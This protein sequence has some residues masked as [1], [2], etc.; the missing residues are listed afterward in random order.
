MNRSLK[1]NWKKQNPMVAVTLALLGLLVLPS[2]AE[3][4]R[5]LYIS[6]LAASGTISAFDFT[7]TGGL[8]SV[9]DLR[10]LPTPLLVASRL[11]LMGPTSTPATST[12]IP[13]LPTLTPS[14]LSRSTRTAG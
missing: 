10:S 1:T 7:A 13:A 6:T 2:L 9:A 8:Q 12:P 14:R 3:A 11:R 5:N 4:K